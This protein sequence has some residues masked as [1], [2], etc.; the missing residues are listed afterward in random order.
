MTETWIA[1][2]KVFLYFNLIELLI[3]HL[4][5]FAIKITSQTKFHPFISIFFLLSPSFLDDPTAS[6]MRIVDRVGTLQTHL[7]SKIF[8]KFLIYALLSCLE[9]F[10][11]FLQKILNILCKIIALLFVAIFSDG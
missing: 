6:F 8:Q 1:H 9:P 11:I 4:A 7:F 2:F 5:L 3:Q 10:I